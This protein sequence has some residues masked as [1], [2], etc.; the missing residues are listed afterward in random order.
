M[1][2]PL[3][4]YANN[5]TAKYGMYVPYNLAWVCQYN[6]RLVGTVIVHYFVINRHHIIW[7][8]GQVLFVD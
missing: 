1:L 4:A 2:L 3:L 5:D 8:I 7:A 6:Y